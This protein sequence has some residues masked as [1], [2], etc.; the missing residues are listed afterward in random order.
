MSSQQVVAMDLYSAS[1]EERD[2]ICCFLVFQAVGELPNMTKYPI[3]EH[4]VIG[5]VA[6][7]ESQ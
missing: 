3:K 6:Q 2:T 5:E 4:R 7:S 1:A